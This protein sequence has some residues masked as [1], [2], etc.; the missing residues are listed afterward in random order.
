MT[1]PTADLD[2][3]PRRRLHGHLWTVLPTLR[4]QLRPPPAPTPTTVRF[5]A[6][7]AIY[8]EVSLSGELRHRE[9]AED[10]VLLV[11]GLG[12]SCR[13]AYVRRAAYEFAGAGFATFA[14]DL[15]GAERR[16]EAI[17]NVALHDD[18]AA[19]C[20]APAMRRY[21]RIFV[22]GF[23]MGGHVGIHFAAAVTD[24]RV[25]AV[26][27]SCAPLDLGA[28]QRHIDTPHRAG[29]R[30]YVLAGLKAIYAA[31]AARRAV[32]TPEPQVRRCR[33]FHE[34][35]RLVIAPQFGFDSPESFYAARSA[36]TVLPRLRVPVRLVL[37]ASDPVIPPALALPWWSQAAAGMLE[38]HVA[39]RGGHL[40][41]GSDLDLG[42]HG[43]RGL[44]PQLAASWA[45]TP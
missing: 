25:R 42:V 38:V 18:L 13:S 24:P 33:T 19:A 9:G 30:H 16:G 15:R 45:R 23:S 6:A 3:P 8:G 32:P 26:A 31:V 12:G 43:P 20:S 29:Y 34:W 44:V 27:A 41:F 28:T 4:D 35:D 14:L 39:G 21:R 1:M 5:V 11:H 22:L 36:R 10:V 2:P 17:Y 37:A 7:D 40:H